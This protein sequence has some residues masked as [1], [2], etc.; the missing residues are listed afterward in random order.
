MRT[1]KVQYILAYLAFFF[2]F[3]FFYSYNTISISRILFFEHFKSGNYSLLSNS[4]QLFLSLN[5]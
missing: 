1:F 2:F 4:K 3:F 5:L